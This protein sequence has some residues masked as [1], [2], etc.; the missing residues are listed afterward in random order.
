MIANGSAKAPGLAF[1]S[2][3]MVGIWRPGA[4]KIAIT[5][6]GNA[7]SGVYV[8]NGNVGI[9][10]AA[11]TNKLDVVGGDLSFAGT[12]SGASMLWD[13]SADELV[14]TKAKMSFSGA[15]AA[16]DHVL[17]F[18][19]MTMPAS[20][21]I[22]RGGSYSTPLAYT[23]ASGGLLQI[24][25]SQSRDTGVDVAS[26]LYGVTTGQAG[27]LGATALI[28]SNAG[29]PGPKTLEGGQ[30]MAGLRAG[31]YLASIAGDGTAGMYGAWLKVYAN[32]T[33]VAS[34]GCRVAAVWLDNQMSCAVGGEEYAAFV[35]TGGSVPDAVF[36]FETSSNGW[37]SF[38]YFDETS[39][40]KQPVSTKSCVTTT[41]DSDASVIWNLNG[42]A[43]YMPLYV[44]AHTS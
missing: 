2:D 40:N 34:A 27:A 33:S 39:Y 6:L 41:N 25:Y 22:I 7:T 19:G 11:P 9:G 44:V 20:K 18:S 13:F 29:S 31:G 36:G 21:N 37:A 14:M 12:T 3:P 26:F 32:V 1:R 15:L 24:Y 8:H 17:D 28:E 10:T 16:A 4:G 38:A 23:A 35:T 42:T 30:F 43:Y 5:T